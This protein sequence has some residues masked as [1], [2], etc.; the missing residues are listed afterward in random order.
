MSTPE[1]KAW[2]WYDWANSAF[3]TSVVTLFLGP[4]L[5]SIAKNAA[6]EEPLQILGFGVDPRA[7]WGYS[8]SLSVMLQVLVMPLVGALADYAR[9][10]KELLALLAFI[11]AGATML[12]FFVEGLRWQLGVLLFL[13]ANVAAG[14]SQVI[15]HSFLPEIAAPQDRDAVSSRGWAFGYLGGGLLLLLN[16]LLFQNAASLGLSEGLAVRI[17]LASAGVWWL[18]FTFPSLGGLRN[19]GNVQSGFAWQ[20]VGASLRQ[21]KNTMREVSGLRQTLIFLCAYLLYNDAIQAVIVLAAQFG[22]EQL[23]MSMGQ[24]TPAILMVQFVAFLGALLFQKLAAKLS[25][26]TALL[27]SLVIWTAAVC[28]IAF[29]VRDVQGYYAM[30]FVVGLVLGGSQALSRSLYSQ[31][32]PPGREAECFSIYEISD[33]GTSWITPLTFA[34]AVQLTGNFRLSV[35]SLIFFFLSGLLVLFFVDVKRGA[36]E[37]QAMTPHP[38]AG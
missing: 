13:I 11:G 17:C 4:W 27:C 25:A 14:A 28:C 38:N 31:L 8:V 32:I 6:G 30:C 19:R 23:G 34:I 21:L 24:L 26:R 18:L 16:L 3:F 2:Y 29:L 20:Q 33:K 36:E 12:M 37:A 35:L 7:L 22:S 1:Q 9:R 5:T 10:K 15:Y